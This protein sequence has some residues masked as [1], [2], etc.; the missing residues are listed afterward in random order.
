M[1]YPAKHLLT[2]TKTYKSSRTQNHRDQYCKPSQHRI[3]A[4]GMTVGLFQQI[5]K[6]NQNGR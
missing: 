1:N 4:I 5:S 3:V 2:V 6:N